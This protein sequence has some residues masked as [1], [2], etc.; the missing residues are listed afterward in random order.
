MPCMRQKQN[1]KALEDL[2]PNQLPTC[3]HHTLLS[4]HPVPS[5]SVRSRVRLGQLESQLLAWCPG[6]WGLG[7]QLC[8]PLTLVTALSL[9][10]QPLQP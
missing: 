7:S 1:Q 8:Q 9:A 3:L 5:S 6:V 10:P 2:L 4:A